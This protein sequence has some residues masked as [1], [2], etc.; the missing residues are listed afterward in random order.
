MFRRGRATAE[1]ADQFASSLCAERS[2]TTNMTPSLCPSTNVPAPV[3]LVLAAIAIHRSVV[4]AQSTNGDP[5]NY[6]YWLTPGRIVGIAIGAVAL[7]LLI[8][9]LILLVCRRRRSARATTSNFPAQPRPYPSWQ[10]QQPVQTPYGLGATNVGCTTYSGQAQRI[11]PVGQGSSTT[12]LREVQTPAPTASSQVQATP[13]ADQAQSIAP[14]DRTHSL[15]A[16]PS[17]RAQQQGTPVSSPRFARTEGTPS[18]GMVN[19]SGQSPPPYYPV[20]R[21]PFFPR[22]LHGGSHA[23]VTASF[24]P[25]PPI[26]AYTTR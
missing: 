8:L 25:T 1:L 22:V 14:T 16:S 7:A 18:A 11:A 4:H 15:S 17:V 9:S 12:P 5:Y 10:A 13:P 21:P 24:Q 3:L 19:G 26:P 6:Y 20:S 23:N 2:T